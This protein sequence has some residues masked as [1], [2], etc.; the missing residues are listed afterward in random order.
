MLYYFI[1]NFL[2]DNEVEWIEICNRANSKINPQ[3]T[4]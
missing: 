3:K 4:I 2:V 1:N